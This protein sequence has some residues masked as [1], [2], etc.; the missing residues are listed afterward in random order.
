MV[1]VSHAFLSPFQENVAHLDNPLR[2]IHVQLDI[3]IEP[4]GPD[5]G[6]R[7][8][9]RKG[10]RKTRQRRADARSEQDEDGHEAGE[11][12][13]DQ[14]HAPAH[15][16]V[17]QPQVPRRGRVVVD[18][19][20]HALHVDL[21]F[22]ETADGCD[23]GQ[24]GT[25][26]LEDG[27]LGRALQSLDGPRRVQIPDGEVQADEEENAGEE[28]N[29]RR[30]EETRNDHSH[31]A[32]ER[33]GAKAQRVGEL[34]V[35]RVEVACIAVQ[36]APDGD[37]IEPSDGSTEDRE[38]KL[39]EELAAGPDR[40]EVDVKELQGANDRGYDGQEDVNAK[41]KGQVALHPSE[42]CGHGVDGVLAA[43]FGI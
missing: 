14:R 24:S 34:R 8:L 35:D 3:G 37:G 2:S 20:V 32:E 26:L 17:E 22:V 40:S 33:V 27:R 21:G 43:A 4:N 25:E 1:F 15:P 36:D 41:I 12:G 6:A 42:R 31:E 5:H 16:P 10:K 18:L 13:A 29:V 9:E 30:D 7:E 11:E 38:I 23:A 39:G 28:N 19:A